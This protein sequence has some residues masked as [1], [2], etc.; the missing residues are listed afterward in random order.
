MLRNLHLLF[1]WH[2]IGQM[3]GGYFAKFCGLLRIYELYPNYFAKII[4]FLFMNF[5]NFPLTFDI[6]SN[7]RLLQI[8]VALS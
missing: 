3:I 8:F 7:L 2:Y 6:T 1:D 4:I 5:G